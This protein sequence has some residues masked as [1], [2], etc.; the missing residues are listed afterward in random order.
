MLPS[1]RGH[2]GAHSPSSTPQL[3]LATPPTGVYSPNVSAT[4]SVLSGIWWRQSCPAQ[5]S[6]SNQLGF[7]QTKHL[8]GSFS[9]APHNS[10]AGQ[11]RQVHIHIL[12]VRNQGP[13]R[14]R[15][16]GCCL[17]KSGAGIQALRL[18]V[19]CPF[20]SSPGCLCIGGPA[21]SAPC[22]LI[23]FL[24]SQN[25]SQ[26]MKHTKRRKLTVE[27]FNRALRWS[28]VEVSGAQV[29]EGSAGMSLPP[30][31]AQGW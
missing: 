12:H 14:H 18:L 1:E 7:R 5:G 8:L 26:F 4:Y 2:P 17:H 24:P 31:Q 23:L 6:P 28:S 25:S 22:L 19:W 16:I 27:D 3:S 10:P 30:C 15:D 21:P 13:E 20:A 9:C 29:A 11:P